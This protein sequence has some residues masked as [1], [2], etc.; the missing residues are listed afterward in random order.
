ME[1][2]YRSKPEMEYLLEP[3]LPTGLSMMNLEGSPAAYWGEFG[4]VN[5]G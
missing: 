4:G 5:L 3:N 2:E 1:L